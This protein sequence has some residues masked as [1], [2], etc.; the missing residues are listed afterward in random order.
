MPLPARSAPSTPEPKKNNV[1]LEYHPYSER[2]TQIFAFEDFQQK[3]P[4]SISHHHKSDL[5]PW[6][7]FN[8]CSDFKFSQLALESNL[9]RAQVEK[10]LS[11]F[12][13]CHTG[14]DA[15]TLSGH[16][17][18]RKH[19]SESATKYKH[20]ITVKH[21]AYSEKVSFW[22][23]DIWDWALDLIRNKVLTSKFE[24]D[25]QR[26]YKYDGDKFI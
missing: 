12:Q 21:G 23:L 14:Q 16:S 11:I 10:L 24:W 15:L 9:S 7:P 5:P 8:T 2:P 20:I 3:E 19:W 17:D 13:W 6:H 1:K 26:L 22:C 4:I 18:M 25:A